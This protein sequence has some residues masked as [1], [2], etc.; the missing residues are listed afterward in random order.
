VAF[1]GAGLVLGVLALG[2]KSD[3]DDV[4]KP[5]CPRDYADELRAYRTERNLSYLGFALG[6]TGI[7]AGTYLLVGSKPG[8]TTTALNLSPSSVT[9]SRSFQ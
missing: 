8:E 7:A 1:T 2:H 6:A 9:L 5:G 4:C 3:L